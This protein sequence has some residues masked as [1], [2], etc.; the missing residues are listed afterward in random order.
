MGSFAP[1]PNVD[2][3]DD[4]AVEVQYMKGVTRDGRIFDVAANLLDDKEWAGA[5]FSPDGNYLFANTQGATSNFDPANPA[6]HGR[7]YVIWGPW[8]SGAL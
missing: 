2:Q 5:C 3:D 8:E 7:T 4:D 1:L 6:D